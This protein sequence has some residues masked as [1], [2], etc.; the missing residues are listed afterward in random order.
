MLPR[1]RSTERGLSHKRWRVSIETA[2]W[3]V[4]QDWSCL[5]PCPCVIIE[6]V[7]C[8]CSLSKSVAANSMCLF[9]EHAKL[10]VQLKCSRCLFLLPTASHSAITYL[11]RRRLG[12]VRDNT[13]DGAAARDAVDIG[14]VWHLSEHTNTLSSSSSSLS[15][16]HIVKSSTSR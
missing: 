15:G 6:N 9:L 2:T 13:A 16:S 8:V 10:Y 5:L 12:D 4:D 1:S 11:L 7:T 14:G 3:V